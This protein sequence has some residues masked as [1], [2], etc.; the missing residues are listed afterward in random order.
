MELVKNSLNA[1]KLAMRMNQIIDIVNRFNKGVRPEQLA[2]DYNI[3][4]TAVL[5]IIKANREEK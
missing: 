1:K 5:D 3:S 2:V 4:K